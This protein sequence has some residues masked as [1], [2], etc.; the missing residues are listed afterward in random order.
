MP[1]I[2]TVISCISLA[3]ALVGLI[4]QHNCSVNHER[5]LRDIS[6]LQRQN[7]LRD[8]YG[9]LNPNP[10]GVLEDTFHEN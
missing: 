10:E 7:A 2:L 4:M 6:Q 1:V 8:L 9:G 5:R 3:T